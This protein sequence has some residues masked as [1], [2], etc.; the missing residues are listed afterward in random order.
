MFQLRDQEFEDKEFVFEND[1][2]NYLGP[3]LT[4]KQCRLI[5]RTSSRGL[6]LSSVNLDNCEIFAK[7]KL[8]NVKGWCRAEISK[9]TFR[10]K[11]FSNDFGYW[12][13]Y[14][15][16]GSMEACDFT[17]AILDDCRFFNCKVLDMKFPKWPCF[18]ILHPVE[19]FKALKA[20]DWTDGQAEYMDL[21]ASPE[22]NKGL[23]AIVNLASEFLKVNGGLEVELRDR[24]SRLDF[25]LL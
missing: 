13:L 15:D 6:V 10:G 12:P 22:D 20:L 14:S 3:N 4:L 19:N 2:V 24:L 5:L 18:T 9:C 8:A 17:E 7:K 11:Y 1:V 16:A 25:V 21:F 23:S